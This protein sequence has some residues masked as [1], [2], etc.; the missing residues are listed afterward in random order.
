MFE[1]N[2]KSSLNLYTKFLARKLAP[3]SYTARH[4]GQGG[5]GGEREGRFLFFL[6]WGALCVRLTAAVLFS[7]YTKNNTKYTQYKNNTKTIQKQKG[8]PK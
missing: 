3:N 7:G 1:L 4:A 5:R 2:L 8:K 6:K